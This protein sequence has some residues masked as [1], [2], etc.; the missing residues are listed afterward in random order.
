MTLILWDIDGTLVRGRGGRITMNAFVD[1]LKLASKLSHIEYPKDSHGNTD[2]QIALDMLIAASMDEHAAAAVLI[3]RR[4]DQHVQ[5]DLTIG[6]AV[7]VL[8]ILD[9]AELAGELERVDEG[10]HGDAPAAAADECPIDIPENQCH[11]FWQKK[12]RPQYR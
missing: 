1:A 3:H 6:V 7:R 11:R 8:R 9:V 4:G 5:R 10:V 12:N 2:S